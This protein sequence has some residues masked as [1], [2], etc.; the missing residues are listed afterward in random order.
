MF[1]L[2]VDNIT[3]ILRDTSK[4]LDTKLGMWMVADDGTDRLIGEWSVKIHSS[5]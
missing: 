4:K 1:V 5:V 3:N 2:V